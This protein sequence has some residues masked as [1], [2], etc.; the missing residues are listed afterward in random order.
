MSDTNEQ[1]ENK[2]ELGEQG[3]SSQ[4]LNLVDISAKPSERNDGRAEQDK[5]RPDFANDQAKDFD[6]SKKSL[7]TMTALQNKGAES[8]L[9]QLGEFSIEDKSKKTPEKNKEAAAKAADVD[10]EDFWILKNPK[11]SP[12]LEPTGKAP[13]P[14]EHLD[15]KNT[16]SSEIKDYLKNSKDLDYKSVFKDKQVLLVG[17]DHTDLQ[18]KE[19]I[20]NEAGRLKDAGVTHFG[21]E[22][23]PQKMQDTLD[24]FGKGDKDAANELKNYINNTWEKSYPG[25][26]DSYMKILESMKDNGI[27]IVGL[28][29]NNHVDKNSDFKPRDAA[30]SSA[31]ANVVKNDPNAKIL[32]FG[33]RNHFFGDS[34]ENTADQLQ[35]NHNISSVKATLFNPSAVADSGGKSEASVRQNE[36]G[37]QTINRLIIQ[38]EQQNRALAI[39]VTGFKSDVLISLP[40]QQ[41][42]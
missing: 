5:S 15:V 24:R 29:I 8:F 32:A 11:Q 18:A 7:S 28:D 3:N 13:K 2:R 10:G 39:P 37:G 14:G 17:E 9:K 19:N 16:S 38:S 27:K 31:I 34:G 21:A 36:L 41:R 30:W 12:V 6:S 33:G 23:I 4:P 25:T 22:I 26:G 40:K 1:L 20:A 35:N 42:K